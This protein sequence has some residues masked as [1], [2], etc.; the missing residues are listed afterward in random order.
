[1][2]NTD[3]HIIKKILEGDNKAFRILYEKYSKLFFLIC[4]RYFESKEDAQDML[5][6]SF[7][8][9]FRDLK[10]F[11]T[12]RG[13][14]KHWSKRVVINTCLQKLRKKTVLDDF[15]TLADIDQNI[16]VSPSV[17]NNLGLEELTKVI[18]KLPTGR[19][20]VFN[21]YVIDGYT[22]QEISEQLGISISTSKTQLMKAKKVLQSNIDKLNYTDIGQ[23]AWG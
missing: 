18:H 2:N 5:Q 15:D 1:M 7:I 9:I 17:L 23:Y 3:I 14:F 21:L 16:G 10:Q 6:E 8:K 19:R 22:H 11:D 13:Q 4:R 20:I 12:N